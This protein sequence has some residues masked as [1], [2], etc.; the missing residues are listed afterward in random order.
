MKRPA[1]RLLRRLGLDVRPASVSTAARR[2]RILEVHGIDVVLDVGANVGQYGRLLRDSG[3]PGRIVSFEPQ[4]EQFELL[5]E[6]AGRDPAWECRQLALGERD[7][8]AVL[9]VGGHSETSSFLPVLEELHEVDAWRPAGSEPVPIRRLDSV[10][11]EVIGDH[12]R[13][14]L[15]LDVQ[16]YELAVL[17]GARA[18]L[19]RVRAVEAELAVVPQYAGQ[20]SYREVIDALDAE[21][22]ELAYV[23]PGYFHWQSGHL[24]YVDGFFVR[25]REG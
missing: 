24:V 18:T 7:G 6:A 10:A 23:D 3:Y 21:G 19:G 8:D 16:G 17:E 11:A 5:Q 4:R 1:K 20:P 22:F 9:H 14:Y 15:K 13:P 25:K 12:E 2:G